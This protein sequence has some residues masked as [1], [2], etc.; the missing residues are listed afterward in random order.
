M[1][2]TH[3]PL[4][5]SQIMTVLSKEPVSSRSPVVLNWRQMTSA[6]CPASV[7]LSTPPCSTLH[8]RAVVS[9]LPVAR[10]VL[11]GLN[12]RH[13]ISAVCPRNVCRHLPV[14]LL[15]SCQQYQSKLRTNGSTKH[16]LHVLSN[17]PVAILSPYGL[18][19]AMAYT[20]FLC[21]SSVCSSSPDWVSH[22]L[23]VRS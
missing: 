21:P 8:S 20:T 9:I 1:L 15:H 5:L 14:A 6:E 17:D 12:A 22:T 19:Y 10:R 23:H 4:R 16:T 11:W 13:T 3:A 18:L 2:P 7:C